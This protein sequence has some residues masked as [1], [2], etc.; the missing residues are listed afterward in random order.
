M[1]VFT[2]TIEFLRYIVADVASISPDDAQT[3]LHSRLEVGDLTVIATFDEFR[4]ELTELEDIEHDLSFLG[5]E[6]IK[7]PAGDSTIAT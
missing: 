4:Q 2:A 3:I 6:P 7:K 1:A 5:I